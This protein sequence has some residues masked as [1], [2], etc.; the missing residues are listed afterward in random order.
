MKTIAFLVIM[1]TILGCTKSFD[2]AGVKEIQSLKQ[3]SFAASLI[4]TISLSLNSNKQG[5]VNEVLK[6]LTDLQIQLQND[7][8]NDDAVFLHKNESYNSHINK[9][10]AAIK[11]LAVEIQALTKR[12]NEL[13]ALIAQAIKNIKS[14][15]ERI[16]NLQMTMVE[17][18]AKLEEDKKYYN[19][20]AES[21]AQVN[22]KLLVV[23]EKLAKMVGSSSGVGVESHIEKT[24]S[25][26]RDIAYRAGNAAGAPNAV[27]PRTI[28]VSQQR[29]LTVLRRSFIQVLKAPLTASLAQLYLQADQKA[30]KK[31]MQIIAKFA[32]DCL[33]EKARA[34][35]KLLEAI[36]TH[37]NLMASMK[38]EMQLNVDARTKQEANK[39]AYENE[40][41]T[42]E[43]L[44]REK[45]IRKAALEKERSINQ[46]LQKNLNA[47][48]NKEKEDRA[49]EMKVVETLL[50]I[51]QSRLMNN[52]K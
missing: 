21:L 52:K 31:L 33:V 37:K 41:I 24:D 35:A 29:R 45:E 3:N 30:L 5:G 23:N 1:I 26:K 9:L 14:F 6:M 18:D 2:F 42:K 25:E 40:K 43:T 50:R 46:E 16:A 11:V 34:E 44:R 12:I 17:L 22:V 8:K 36:E 32:N 27:Q 4:E 20:K 48:Y 15:N 38:K 13:A 10:T 51:V 39:K 7:Q 19:H 28:P 47:T 49:Q